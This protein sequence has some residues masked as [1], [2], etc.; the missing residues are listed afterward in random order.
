GTSVTVVANPA[1]DGRFRLD[2]T[3][4]HATAER[5]DKAQVD[6]ATRSTRAFRLVEVGAPAVASLNVPGEPAWR[7][8]V[9][10]TITEVRDTQVR[11]AVAPRARKAVAP[12]NDAAGRPPAQHLPLPYY[13][14]PT[15]PL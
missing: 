10:A 7:L 15:P 12:T 13:Y 5:K 3:L 1:P 8:E 11:R 9:T 6:L 4:E 14:R 2:L